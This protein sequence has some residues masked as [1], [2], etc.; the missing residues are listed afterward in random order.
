M[1]NV[2]QDYIKQL[3]NDEGIIVLYVCEA[4]SRSWGLESP[5]SD[6]DVRF[7]YM[8]PTKEYL[9]IDPIGVGKRK[10]VIEQK[11]SDTLDISGWELTKT[12]RLFRKSNPTLLEWLHSEM[13]YYQHSTTI[14]TIKKL[15]PTVFSATTCLHHYVNMASSNFKKF[16]GDCNHSVKLLINVLRPI[17]ICKWIKKHNAF[18]P[19]DM[20]LVVEQ[21]VS[22]EEIEKIIK[23]I[24]QDKR[25][26]Q[27]NVVPN[28]INALNTYITKSLQD[29]KH[30]LHKQPPLRN[31]GV[32]K[33]L[34]LVF[35]NA[36]REVSN[37]N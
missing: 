13:L 29:I 24:L 36:L 21:V 35:Q 18:P 37:K 2:I 17:L 10:D 26:G 23:E 19:L 5:M 3:E 33:K 7:I 4:G 9:R 31:Q 25:L 6:Y 22:D 12:L 16:D 15:E 27:T 11:I 14:E 8:Y 34:D 20:D 1:K 28:N 32:T 30:H